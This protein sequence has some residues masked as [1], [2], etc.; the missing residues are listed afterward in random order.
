M[1]AKYYIGILSA[2]MLAV[3]PL[4]AQCAD[5]RDF[6]NDDASIIVNNY[7]DDYDYYYSSRIN[8]FHRSYAAFDY[9]SPVFT[10]TYWYNYRPYSWGVSIYGGTGLGFGLSFNYPVYYYGWNYGNWY[11]YDY[12]WYDP[13]YGSYWWGYDPYYYSWYSPVVININ[14]GNRWGHNYW[15]WNRHNYW[16]G[17]RHNYWYNDYRPMYN[18][19]NNYYNYPAT[20]YSSREYP[21]RGRPAEYNRTNSGGVS[22]REAIPAPDSRTGVNSGSDRVGSNAGINNNPTR[23]SAE[24][25]NNTGNTGNNVNTRSQNENRNQVSTPDNVRTSTGN[26][27]SAVTQPSMSSNRRIEQPVPARSSTPSRTGTTMS[28]GRSSS[29]RSAS[30]SSTSKSSS[31]SS[32][33]SKKS[34]R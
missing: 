10:E 13:Y 32:S 29:S 1:K 3:F 4:K 22:R 16:G 27:T 8:R 30:N 6:R 9:Y 28:Q 25:R 17:N 11:S 14:F 18:T 15:G 31:G 7:Y 20:R 12:G 33:S 21:D 19:Y 26:T 24:V 2:L 23:R 34:R 5:N